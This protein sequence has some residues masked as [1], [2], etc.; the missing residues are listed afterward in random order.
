MTVNIKNSCYIIGIM[1]GILGICLVPSVIVEVI[2]G[3]TPE[4]QALTITLLLCLVP[5]V[6]VYI[7]NKIRKEKL[8]RI[9]AR[10]G[11]FIVTAAW[12]LYSAI[13]AI[14]FVVTDSIPDFID[15][16]F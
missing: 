11:F 4:A 13:T 16:F 6:I 14:P 15:A 2:Y 10:D 1:I 7:I 5:A 12:L 8:T 9:K 3:E